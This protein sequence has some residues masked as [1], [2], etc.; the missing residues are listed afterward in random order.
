MCDD[1]DDDDAI[2]FVLADE[3]TSVFVCVMVT[4][5]LILFTWTCL[6]SNVR[7]HT[8]THTGGLAFGLEP[9]RR[10]LAIWLSAQSSRHDVPGRCAQPEQVRELDR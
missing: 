5:L 7:A 1:D 2:L 9:H 6:Q 4:G 3:T 8:H 10:R